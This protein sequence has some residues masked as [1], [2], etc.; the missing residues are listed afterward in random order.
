MMD[1][2]FISWTFIISKWKKKLIQKN[3]PSKILFNTND[4]KNEF[5]I[6]QYMVFKDFFNKLVHMFLKPLRRFIPIELF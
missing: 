4:L 3:H 2:E 5:K 6:Q 1:V